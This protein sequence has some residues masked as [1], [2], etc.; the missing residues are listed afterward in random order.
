M[1]RG[2]EWHPGFFMSKSGRKRSQ[3]TRELL[4]SPQMQA[5]VAEHANRVHAAVPERARDG[6]RATHYLSG[7]RARSSVAA[8]TFV[9]RR[10]EAKHNALA[11]ALRS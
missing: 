3:V 8:V 11:R 1:A 2:T 10:H 6:Y 5:A 4:K 9:A 7:V